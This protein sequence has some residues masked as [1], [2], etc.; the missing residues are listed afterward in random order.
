MS[1]VF[2]GIFFLG[3]I[4]CNITT[5]NFTVEGVIKNTAATTV[6]LEQNP[7]NRERPLVLDSAAIKKDGSFK[8]TTTTN[9]EGVYSLRAG[10]AK[11]PFAVLINDS[12]KLIVN[13]DMNQ[14]GGY[15]VIGSPASTALMQFEQ[16]IRRQLALLS[17]YSKNSDSLMYV[18]AS[19]AAMQKKIDSTRSAD[20]AGYE[21]TARE[22]KNFVLDLTQRVNSPALTIYVV[23]SFQKIAERNGITPLNLT[24]IASVVNK[25]INQFP[26]NT[27]LLEWKKTLRPGKAPEFTLLDTSGHEVS[28]A[29]FKGKYVLIDFWASWCKPCRLEN[30]NILAAYNQ[31]KNKNF[32]I[33]GVSLDNNKQAWLKAIHDDGLTWNHVSDL[34][35]WESQ[36]VSLYG[37]QSLP[38]NFLIDPAGNIVAEDV[39]GRELFEALGRVL[40]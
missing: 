27:T 26:D 35:G 30:P 39:K 21:T 33:I 20:S 32:T 8:L 36:V 31:F 13:A 34:K 14:P 11:L 15:I 19:D 5:G 6:Y 7:P 29:S 1:R 4:S 17:R 25:A 23:S 3:L 10:D 37:V 2:I 28:L 12:K 9:E 40:R 38:H 24:E 18:Q 22:M 16:T